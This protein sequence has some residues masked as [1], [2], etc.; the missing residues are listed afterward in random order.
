MDQI[1]I[2]TSEQMEAM[3]KRELVV[4]AA[5]V[6]NLNNILTDIRTK[7]SNLEADNIK[8]HEQNTKMQERLFVLESDKILQTNVN[9]L[10]R[11]D[12]DQ[13]AQKVVELEKVA[14]QNAQ[15]SRNRQLEIHNVPADIPSENLQDVVSAVLSVTGHAVSRNDLDKCHRLKRETSVICEFK[16]RERR[17]PILHM[18]KNLKTKAAELSALRVPKA[19]IT[20]SLSPY[21]QRLSFICRKLKSLDKISDTWFY[22]GRLFLKNLAGEK[23]TISHQV[24]IEKLFG[25]EIISSFFNT[26]Q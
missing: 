2:L 19:I 4:Y 3:D 11:S 21:Y 5:N 26:P 16:Y 23:V 24:D 25:V 6:S 9:K 14:G 7:L 13:L 22:N 12:I 10:L 1:T 18:R 8:L 15:Y 20:E 17:D